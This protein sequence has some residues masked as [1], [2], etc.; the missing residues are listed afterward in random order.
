MAQLIGFLFGSIP[1]GYLIGLINGVDV[2]KVGS[3]NIGATNIYRALG[4]GWANLVFTLDLVKGLIP[5]AILSDPWVLPFVVL[6]HCFT[7]WLMFRGGKGVSTLI[8][9]AIPL[10]SLPLLIALIVWFV[11]RRKSRIVSLASISF[12]IS[13]PFFIFVLLGF[14][15]LPVLITSVIV[16]LRHYENLRRLISGNEPETDFM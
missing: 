11:V 10:Y 3:G 4:S 2:R 8:G 13:L 5:V 12:A 9:A 1:S 15:S 6:G 16:I 14:F 7:P